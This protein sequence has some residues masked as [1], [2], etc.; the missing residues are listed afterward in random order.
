MVASKLS[1]GGFP[2]NFIRLDQD[3]PT[4]SD[5]D[6]LATFFDDDSTGSPKM[7]MYKKDD[8]DE[9]EIERDTYIIPGQSGLK[10]LGNTCYMNAAL[11]CLASLPIFNSYLRKDKFIDRLR[12]NKMEFIAKKL[13]EKYKKGEKESINISND[14]VEKF[15]AETVSYQLSR[16]FKYM[17]KENATIDPRTFKQVIGNVNSEFKGYCQNDSQEVLN[18]ILDSIHEEIKKSVSL[19][20]CNIPTEVKSLIDVRRHCA[21]VMKSKEASPEEKE[22]AQYRYKFYKKNNVDATTILNAYIYWKKYVEDNHSIVT[23]LFTGLF[24]S[25][26]TCGE[27]DNKTSKFEPFTSLSVETAPDGETTLE[28]CL[29][30]FSKEEDLTGTEQYY[31]ENCKCKVDA[32]KKIYIW[33]APEVLIIH[34]KRFKT[35][36]VNPNHSRMS[37]TSSKVVFPME[38]F[39]IDNNFSD[40]HLDSSDQ[41]YSLWSLILHRG[42]CTGGHYI[43]YCRNPINKLWYEFNDSTVIHVPDEKI[44]QEVITENAYVMFYVRNNLILSD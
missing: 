28:E 40:I 44:E 41:Y 35:V 26:I 9:V 15:C 24:F 36:Y 14:A 2:T 43:A 23:D 3:S 19:E 27:C 1:S 34:L 31:C 16:L 7:S 6:S 42:S 32:K 17:W 11:Q 13:R 10:N 18:V 29:K 37:K 5:S 33:E 20:F 39:S 30:D 8:K 12:N 4:S 22:Q 25:E 21:D 38:D